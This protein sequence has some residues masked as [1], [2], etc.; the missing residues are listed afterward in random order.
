[1]CDKNLGLTLGVPKMASIKVKLTES[2]LKNI[3]LEL[4]KLM[5]LRSPV[6]IS[7]LENQIKRVNAHKYIICITALEAEVQE[8]ED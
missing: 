2:I 6:F 5:T 1:M 4:P 3:P 8:K 7:M